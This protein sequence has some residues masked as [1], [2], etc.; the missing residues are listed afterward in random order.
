MEQYKRS[1]RQSQSSQKDKDK[2]KIAKECYWGAP[3]TIW[4]ELHSWSKGQDWTAKQREDQRW[5]DDKFNLLIAWKLFQNC[6]S[7]KFQHIEFAIYKYTL[8][9]QFISKIK[10][11]LPMNFESLCP[12]NFSVY[13][14]KQSESE[15]IWSHP[16]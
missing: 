13:L 2:W 6:T 9:I 3:R 12:L 16:S 14:K 10:S 5:T 7:S 4:L 15:R 11:T 1:Q 8:T